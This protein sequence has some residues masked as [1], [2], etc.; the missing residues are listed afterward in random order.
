[1]ASHQKLDQELASTIQV[2]VGR[3][4]IGLEPTEMLQYCLYV[5]GNLKQDGKHNFA[6]FTNLLFSACEQF[7]WSDNSVLARWQ[8]TKFA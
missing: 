4:S 2:G 3:I 5:V 7:K 6:G 1:M 8:C